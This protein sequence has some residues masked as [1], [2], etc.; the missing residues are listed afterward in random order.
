MLTLQK[1]KELEKFRTQYQQEIKR[2]KYEPR[3]KEKAL[4]EASALL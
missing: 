3:G 1:Q 2:L 4:A